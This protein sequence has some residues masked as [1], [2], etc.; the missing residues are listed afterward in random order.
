MLKPLFVI[1]IA[2][3][4]VACQAIPPG[5]PVESA[6]S[7]AQPADSPDE[8]YVNEQGIGALAFAQAACGGCHSVEP[9]DLSPNPQAPAFAE[10]A[11]RR[12][13][14]AETL[15]YW[16]RDAHNYPE[17]MDFDLN[18]SRIDELTTYILTLRD[19]NYQP[20]SY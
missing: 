2:V 8:R 11:N 4:V 12:G 16:L 6:A 20:P 5:E 9:L 3:G 18:A 10:I 15:S 7:A 1:A 13:L 14:T 19:K 17:A